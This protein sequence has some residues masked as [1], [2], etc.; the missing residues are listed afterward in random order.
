[1]P[2]P[3]RLPSCTLAAALVLATASPALA[4]Q[5]PKQQADAL[6]DQGKQFFAE[7]R[8]DDAYGKFREAATLSPEARFFFNMCYALNFLERYQ[9]AIQACE[10]VPAA[11][12]ADAGLK[13]VSYTHLTLPTSD[14]V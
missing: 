5:S 6:N 14:L 12:G 13:A 1:M 10:Q 4:Q 3:T 9:D 8:Y 7:K 11:D 2:T